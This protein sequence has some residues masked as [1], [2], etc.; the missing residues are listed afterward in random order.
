[1][2]SSF[3]PS[4]SVAVL[5]FNLSLTPTVLFDRFMPSLDLPGEPWRPKVSLWWFCG[6]TL[7]SLCPLLLPISHL[8]FVY[9]EKYFSRRYLPSRE[10]HHLIITTTSTLVSIFLENENIYKAWGLHVLWMIFNTS[11]KCGQPEDPHLSLTPPQM[12]PRARQARGAELRV[13]RLRL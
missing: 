11:I 12:E 4:Y 5:L 2:H 10:N 9:K 6:H 3:F 1:M 8:L 7:I 13:L